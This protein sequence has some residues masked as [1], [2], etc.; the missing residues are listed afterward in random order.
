MIKKIPFLILLLSIIPQLGNGQE[1]KIPLGTIVDSIPVNDSLENDFAIYLPRNFNEKEEWPIIFVFDPEGRGRATAQLFRTI[2][3]KQSYIIA[4]SNINLKQ[5]SLKNNITKVAPLINRVDGMLAIDREQVFLA[6]LAEGGQLASALPFIYN[7][8]AGVLAVENSWLNTDYLNT[9]KEFFFSAIACDDKNTMNVLIE[10]EDYLDRENFPT[11]IN[12]YSCNGKTE[13][14][15]M[16]VIESAVTGFTLQ[17]IKAGERPADLDL[18]TA[19]Y[20]AEVEYAQV[21]RRTRNYYQSF[22]KLKQI[23]DKYDGFGLE[24]DLG[25]QIRD[26]RRN[27]AFKQQRRDYR[28][29]VNTEREKQEEYIYY[30][31][32]DVVTSNF[33]NIGW[34]A[35]QVEDLK[36]Q[37]EKLTG[38]KQK[39]A[40]RLLGFLD[41]LSENYYDSYVNSQVKAKT[42]IFVSVLRTI[43]AKE[44]PKAYLSIIKIAGHDGDHETALLYLEDLL[45]TGYKDME[46]LYDIDGI[47]DLKLSKAYNDKISEYLGKAK[48]FKAT[49]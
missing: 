43:F 37:S 33:E 47:L 6:G 15:N 45:K 9:G 3:E 17:A 48:Y 14:P 22:E 31:D 24:V 34:W 4:A 1:L 20:N 46:G 41:S 7:N 10:I 32:A 5:D 23:E 13:W 25:D 29:V 19:L 28:N 42:K 38:P 18:I 16:D 36:E 11:E 44:D 26:I 30:M 39:M 12:F 49:N 8:I 21:L 40:S 35:A 2:A 27:K